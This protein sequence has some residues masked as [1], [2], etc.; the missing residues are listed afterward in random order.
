MVAYRTIFVY[1][2]LTRLQGASFALAK[3][4]ST[5]V[6]LTRVPDILTH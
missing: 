1:F 5:G 2:V 4:E 6:I 3:R